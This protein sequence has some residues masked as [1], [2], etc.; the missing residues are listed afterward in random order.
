MQN[1]FAFDLLVHQKMFKNFPLLD[2][3]WGG[4]IYDWALHLNK[5]NFP[6]P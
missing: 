1:R 5:L 3:F 6:C 4:A 2:P